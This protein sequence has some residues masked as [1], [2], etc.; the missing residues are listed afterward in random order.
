MF[1]PGHRK[2][3][4]RKKGTPNKRTVD[5][6]GRLQELNC[7]PLAFLANTM[8]DP[9][10]DMPFRLMAAK[11]LCGYMYPKRKPLDGHQND[12][13]PQIHIELI[14]SY[15]DKLGTLPPYGPKGFQDDYIDT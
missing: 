2:A 14:N 6:V 4:G 12:E 10:Q 1:Q 15:G 3:G 8:N 13:R 9:G 5:A 11:E 7:D